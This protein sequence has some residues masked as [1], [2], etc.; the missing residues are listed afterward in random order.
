MAGVPTPGV[1]T[2]DVVVVDADIVSFLFKRDS[3]AARYEPHLLNRMLVLSTQAG[4]EL[5]TW[6]AQHNWG[7]MRRQ[8]LYL[9]VREQV[10]FR[11][12]RSTA[13]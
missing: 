2:S 4:A 5:Y 3:R 13:W 11:R 8:E 7:P 9:Y 12:Q 1:P 6:P 10:I